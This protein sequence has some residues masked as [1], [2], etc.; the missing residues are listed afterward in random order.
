MIHERSLWRRWD[1]T[2]EMGTLALTELYLLLDT[3]DL[4]PQPLDHPVH[5][6]DLLLGISQVVAMPTSC[7]LQFFILVRADTDSL[8]KRLCAHRPHTL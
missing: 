6:C 5:L 7:Q 1:N 4:R 8:G 2:E 3:I